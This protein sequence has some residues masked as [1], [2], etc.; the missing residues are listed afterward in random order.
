ME[1]QF[2]RGRECTSLRRAL[3]VEK[4]KEISARN[5]FPAGSTTTAANSAAGDRSAKPKKSS[6]AVSFHGD[7]KKIKTPISPGR[8]LCNLLNSIFGAK[9]KHRREPPP[10]EEERRNSVRKSRSM[11]TSTHPASCLSKGA[12]PSKSK[13]SV[14]FCPV[15]VILNEGGGGGRLIGDNNVNSFRDL[16]GEKYPNDDEEDGMSCSSSDLFEL[17]NIGG[18][19]GGGEANGDELPVYG[20]ASLKMNKAISHG[21]FM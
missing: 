11:R 20:T 13:R 1:T 6:A 8:K 2:P 9:T 17:E 15:D 21:V 10:A 3:M 16:Q 19:A 4:W 7:L 14:R 18:D 12:A 5:T